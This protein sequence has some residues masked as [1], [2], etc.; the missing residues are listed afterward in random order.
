M[1]AVSEKVK[2]KIVGDPNLVEHGQRASCREETQKK[3]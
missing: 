3:T 1:A 2:G